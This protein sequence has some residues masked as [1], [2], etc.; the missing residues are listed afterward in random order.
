ML[1]SFESGSRK[2]HALHLVAVFLGKHVQCARVRPEERGR[3]CACWAFDPA[4]PG[5]QACRV[6]RTVLTLTPSL[7]LYRKYCPIVQMR[8][9][10]L[11][12]MTS[13]DPEPRG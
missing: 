11:R 9:L 3:G 8:M 6:S 10:R 5:G 2:V 13:K 1:G 7:A 12:E 4:R